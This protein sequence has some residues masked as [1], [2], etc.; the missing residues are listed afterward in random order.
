MHTAVLP[1]NLEGSIYLCIAYLYMCSCALHVDQVR[2]NPDKTVRQGKE[3]AK[4]ARCQDPACTGIEA[5]FGFAYDKKRVRCATH[6]EEGMVYLAGKKCEEPTC[7]KKA[8]FG[9]PDTKV[10]MC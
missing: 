3:K 1:F 10:R 6:I 2:I 9:Q 5:S 8:C 4:Y 7:R